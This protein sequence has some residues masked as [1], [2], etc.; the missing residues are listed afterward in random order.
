MTG[1]LCEYGPLHANALGLLAVTPFFLSP[2]T[3][4]HLGV[5]N[6]LLAVILAEQP[7]T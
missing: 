7:L 4:I 2:A 6:E 3:D 5:A 1:L